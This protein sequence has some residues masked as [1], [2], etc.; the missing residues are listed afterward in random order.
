MNTV[1]ST[2]TLTFNSCTEEYSISYCMTYAV[3]QTFYTEDINCSFWNNL[4]FFMFI[5]ILQFYWLKICV[6]SSIKKCTGHFT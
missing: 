1:V 5:S 2:I 6:N 3:F 4:I